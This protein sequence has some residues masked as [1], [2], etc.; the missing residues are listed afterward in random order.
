M[1]SLLLK[2]PYIYVYIKCHSLS[3]THTHFHSLTH[4]STQ[5]MHLNSCSH[6]HTYNDLY[7]EGVMVILQRWPV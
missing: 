7:D 4:V 5:A 3:L 1:A 2:I 6:P